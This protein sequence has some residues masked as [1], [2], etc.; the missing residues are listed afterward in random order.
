MD[1]WVIV[2][3]L[4]T[5]IQGSKKHRLPNSARDWAISSLRD[6]NVIIDQ[7]CEMEC[8]GLDVPTE[9]Q[10]FALVAIDG[11]ANLWIMG[12]SYN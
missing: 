11:M 6:V 3:K 9:D 7:I 1:P 8:N 4:E 12:F 10:N 5:L 2:N